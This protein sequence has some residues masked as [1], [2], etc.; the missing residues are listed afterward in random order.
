V[1]RPSENPAEVYEAYECFRRGTALLESRDFMQAAV[2]LERA[3]RLEPD[4]ASI[5]EALARAYL[6]VRAYRRAADEFQATVDLSPTN[7]YPHY[8]LG[9]S[10]ERLGDGP[11]AARHYR[12]ARCLGSPLTPERPD[13]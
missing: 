1:N 12:L 10:L 3:K 5:R 8:S 9:R 13:A 6:S 7:H 2:A 4:K 11:G